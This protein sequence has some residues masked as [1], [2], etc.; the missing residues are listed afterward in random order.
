MSSRGEVLT[1]DRSKPNERLDQYL[2]SIYQAV[3]RGTLQRLIKEGHITVNGVKVKPTHAPR[4]GES[5][6]VR[7]PDVRPAEPE[8][9]NIPLDILHEDRDLV[10]LNKPPGLCVHPGNGHETGTL[11]HALLHHC[12]DELSGIGGVARPGIVHR[13]DL[14]TSG[15][16][17]VAKHDQ[18]HIGLSRQFA[19]RTTSKT[20][21]AL[22]CGVMPNDSGEIRVAIARH[23]THRKRMAA[24]D[25]GEGKEAHTDYRVLERLRH[26]TLAEAIIHTGRT[27]QIRVHFQYIGSPLVGDQTYGKRQN[28]Q[29]TSITG[30]QASRQMLHAA[31]LG[32]IHPL[33]EKKM[34]FNAPRP[35]DFELA[36]ELLRN[37]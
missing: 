14:D 27:H 18:A 35:Q 36:I 21:H 26:A 29:L 8:P 34:Q 15:C 31:K 4:A 23:S 2:T 10:V 37:A 20:Y 22:A 7:W 25:E 13:L 12:G 1:V 28:R 19:E 24:K 32:F 30:Y 9:E 3:S 6:E 33:T 17:V 5:I 16:L 11:V